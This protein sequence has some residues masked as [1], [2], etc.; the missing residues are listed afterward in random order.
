MNAIRLGARPGGPAP[1]PAERR[2]GGRF[3]RRAGDGAGRRTEAGDGRA[4][5]GGP[6]RGVGAGGDRETED[7]D[8]RY[9]ARGRRPSAECTP[10]ATARW[11]GRYGMRAPVYENGSRSS[12]GRPWHENA[13]FLQHRVRVLAFVRTS[14]AAVDRSRPNGTCGSP[15]V[16]RDVEPEEAYRPSLHR[17]TTVASVPVPTG[18]PSIRTRSRASSRPRRRIGRRPRDG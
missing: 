6:H 11:D 1:V 18:G 4:L 3:A 13:V 16:G 17:I 7:D 2:D 8:E 15:A 10:G 9:G 14:V 12:R 5:P